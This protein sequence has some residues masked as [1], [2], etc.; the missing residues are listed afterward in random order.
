LHGTQSE[1]RATARFKQK[2]PGWKC[3]CMHGQD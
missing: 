2:V 3:A 1:C